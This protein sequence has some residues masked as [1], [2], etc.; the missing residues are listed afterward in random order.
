MNEYLSTRATKKLVH[1]LQN[2]WSQHYTQSRV[3]V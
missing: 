1:H 3:N 2:I